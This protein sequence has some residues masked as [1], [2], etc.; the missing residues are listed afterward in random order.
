MSDQRRLEEAALALSP[1]TKEHI[2]ALFAA[3][4]PV[5]PNGLLI[6]DEDIV[7]QTVAGLAE[8]AAFGD[9]PEQQLAHKYAWQ[10]ALACGIFPASIDELYRKMS[11]DELPNIT[12]PAMNMRAIPFQSARAVFAAMRE[13]HVGAAIF[14]LSRGEIAFTGQRPMEYATV[15]LCA[16]ITER[17]S[18][19]LFLQGDHFQVSASRYATDPDLELTTVKNLIAEAVAAGFYCIDIDTSTLVDLSF[20]TVDEQQQPNYLLTAKLANFV[21]E[22]EPEGITIS[23]GGEIGEVGEE[24]STAEEVEVFLAGV[25]AHLTPNSLGLTKL[26]IQSGTKHGGNVLKDGSF[27]EMLVDFELITELTNACR[28]H[29]G[30]AGCVQ[31]GA[32]MLTLEK[33]G[34][35]PGSA[36]VEVHLAAAFLNAVYKQLPESL[37]TLADDWAI[38]HFADEWNFD[39]SKEQF[40]HH[41]RRYP[42][43]YF[44]RQWWDASDCHEALRSAIYD[45][46]VAYFTALNATN[47]VQMVTDT[48]KQQPQ[49]WHPPRLVNEQALENE[50]GIR[51]LAD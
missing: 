3:M 11:T 45:Q 27:G 25:N 26:S 31:H 14:E 13:H 38:E 39:W 18:G 35:L 29:S 10:L 34:R 1:T 20:D 46:T 33:L 23:L 50:I 19:P 7:R 51:D 49:Q 22:L 42:I 41:A 17:H 37:V 47:T 30:V 32:S 6:T 8:I 36:C 16:A 5:E 44:K 24:N 48:I 21:R 28:S 15:I 9:R 4:E 43:G 12:V 40:L 2:T